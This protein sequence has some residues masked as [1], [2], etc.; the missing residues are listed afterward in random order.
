MDELMP[1]DYSSHHL[2][3][4]PY[5]VVGKCIINNKELKI[6]HSAPVMSYFERAE[7]TVDENIKLSILNTSN[8]IKI[9]DSKNILT[10]WVE[11][12]TPLIK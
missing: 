10:I 9:N 3:V 12:K 7:Y 1:H 6:E 4:I 2:Y 11:F 8:D 5:Y